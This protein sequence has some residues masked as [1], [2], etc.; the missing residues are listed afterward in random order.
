MAVVY[1]G[2]GANQG[3][4]RDNLLRALAS[5]QNVPEIDITALSRFYR[6][7]PVGGEPGQPDYINAVAK[8]DCSLSPNDL[9]QSCLAIELSMGR[10]RAGR[11]G[12]RTIDVDLLLYDSL[13]ISQPGLIIPHPLIRKRLFVLFPLSDVAPDTLELPP[14]GRRIGDVL[15]AANNDPAL[16]DQKPIVVFDEPL[17]GI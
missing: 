10:I 3:D 13:S 9:L 12:S 15:D 1:L 17:V 2:L 16:A 4:P 6:T 8:I 11:W 14:D 5:L 7:K